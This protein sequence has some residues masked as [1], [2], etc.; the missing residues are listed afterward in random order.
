MRT[1]AIG[2]VAVILTTAAIVVGVLRTT[3]P[4][5]ASSNPDLPVPSAVSSDAQASGGTPSPVP[6]DPTTPTLHYVSNTGPHIAAAANL[7]FDLFDVS[8][9]KSRIDGLGAGQRALVWLG[10][11]D[12]TD[13]TPGYSWSAFTAAV[14][15]LAHDPK[16][17]G[18]YISDEPHPSI[19]STA[20][21]DIRARADYIRAHAPGQK[22]FIVVMDASRICGT[23][24]GCEYRQ[25]NA[26]TTHVDLF[27]I[28]PFPCHSG[29]PCAPERIDVEVERAIDGGIPV[30]D[31][32]PVFQVFGQACSSRAGYYQL[33]SAA[34]LRDMFAQ[35]QASVPDP[36][37][38][39]AYTWRSEGPACPSLDRAKSLQSIVR[40][41]NAS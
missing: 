38:D 19:C 16:V 25:L 33:P 1:R 4:S 40:E 23:H 5:N 6:A 11:L 27:G 37:F 30:N 12:N 39:F 10:N 28:D 32:V 13:C 3:H 29:A 31:I 18:Y 26:H 41:H 24:P 20:V 34:A 15:R 9:N 7:G 35:W 22:S 36:A 14:D 2:T 17:F 8:P 21:A